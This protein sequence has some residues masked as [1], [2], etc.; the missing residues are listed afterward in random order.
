MDT[1]IILLMGDNIIVIS[2]TSY[3]LSVRGFGKLQHYV[4]CQDGFTLDNSYLEERNEIHLVAN[5]VIGW[6][7][8]SQLRKQI[9]SILKN[10]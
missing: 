1:P 2:F 8:M 3:D 6:S 9:T 4:H 7:E 10:I 5:H